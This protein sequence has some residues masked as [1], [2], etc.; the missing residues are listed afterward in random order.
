MINTYTVTF[1]SNGG[2]AVTSKTATYNTAITAPA[3]PTRTGYTFAGWY[4]SATGSTKID[5]VKYK[6]TAN[7]TLYAHWTANTYTVSFDSNGGSAVASKA[8]K[9]NTSITAPKAPARTGYTFAGWYTLTADGAKIDFAKFKVTANSTLYA[10]WT[11]N[12]YTVKFNPNGGSAVASKKANYSTAIAA[13]TDPTRTGYTFAGWYTS[14]TGGAK[15]DFV[16]FVVT[17]NK[18]LYAHWTINTYTV[19]FDSNGGSAVASKTAKYYTKITAPKA[20]TRTGYRFTGWYTLPVGGTKIDFGKFKVRADATQYAHW[21]INTYTVK[22]HS[23][24]GSAVASKTAQ[25]NTAITAPKAPTRR[26]YTFAGWY[27]LATGGIMIDFATFKVIANTT[28][29]AQWTK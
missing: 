18:T 15:I 22:F 19:S 28:L 17:A 16:T 26:G 13:P 1:N 5:F 2:S 10:H 11:I 25:Y 14:A 8:A 6:V 7:K 9:Y 12:T 23:N 29:Y 20:P 24:G 27:T 3:A 4:T 21:S